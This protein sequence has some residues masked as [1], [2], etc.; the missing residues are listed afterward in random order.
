MQQ[1]K[2]II[3][4]VGDRNPANRV[5]VA[6][7]EA[8]TDGADAPSVEWLATERLLEPRAIDLTRFAGL[9]IAPGSPYRSEDGALAAIRPAREHQV[10]LLGTCGGFQHLVLEFARHVLGRVD[11][12][13]E[14][15]H[16]LIS[17]FIAAARGHHP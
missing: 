3:G 7:E 13:H 4:L 2:F 15:T 5:H 6:T 11:A 17:A 8:L 9:L 10:P 12:D 16:P 14:E 1:Q